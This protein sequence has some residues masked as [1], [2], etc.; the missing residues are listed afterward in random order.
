M[1]WNWYCKKGSYN[2][3]AKMNRKKDDIPSYLEREK[4]HHKKTVK[5]LG[6]WIDQ[7]MTLGKH[8]RRSLD[9]AE[10]VMAFNSYAQDGGGSVA[11]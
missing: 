10:R 5:Y 9:K 1:D 2:L 8:V 3:I 4:I 6:V 11:D 7:T